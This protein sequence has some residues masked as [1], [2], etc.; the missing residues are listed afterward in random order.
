M[1]KEN[2]NRYYTKAADSLIDAQNYLEAAKDE[3]MKEGLGGTST[4]DFIDNLI[5][6]IGKIIRLAY[7][8]M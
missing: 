2:F 6:K 5:D 3:L 1:S 7:S 4:Y 8:V